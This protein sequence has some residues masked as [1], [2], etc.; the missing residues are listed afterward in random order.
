MVLHSEPKFYEEIQA[1]TLELGF[2]MPSDREIGSLLRTLAISKPAPRILDLGTG[3]GLSLC[4]L[5]DGMDDAGHLISIELDPELPIIAQRCFA[6]DHRI[7][8]IIQDGAEWLKQQTIEPFYDLIFADT[9][10]GK[11]SHLDITLSLLRPGGFYIID[12]MEP[13]PNWPE[14]HQEKALALEA[15][16]DARQDLAISKLDWSTGIMIC[17]K[18]G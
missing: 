1:Y 8:I 4:W 5:A 18:K 9:W 2:S 16:L 7:Q 17:V 11:Y 12:D 14:G 13:Q 3:T 15:T 6:S 10:P